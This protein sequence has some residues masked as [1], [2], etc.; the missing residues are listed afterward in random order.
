MHLQTTCT[1]QLL[2]GPP[3]VK[4][5]LQKAGLRFIASW[6]GRQARALYLHFIDVKTKSLVSRVG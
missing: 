4:K 1:F 6:E 2:C 3:T 5:T